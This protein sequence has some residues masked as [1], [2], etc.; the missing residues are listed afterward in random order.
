MRFVIILRT[1]KKKIIDELN[2]L[3]IKITNYYK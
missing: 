2:Y 3:R 1:Y